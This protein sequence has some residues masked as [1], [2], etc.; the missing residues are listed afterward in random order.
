VKVLAAVESLVVAELNTRSRSP[1][2]GRLPDK[3]V[4][5]TGGLEP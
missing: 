1:I 5:A 3:H 4:T 2:D